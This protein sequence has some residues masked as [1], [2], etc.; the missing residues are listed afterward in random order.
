MNQTSKV[1]IHHHGGFYLVGG[2]R[3]SWWDDKRF[4][5]G[6]TIKKPPF[7]GCT[8]NLWG[9]EA[10]GHSSNYRD[11]ANLVVGCMDCGCCL[12]VV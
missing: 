11:L 6:G 5:H 4:V 3:P 1:I 2:S 8:W 10:L 9:E 7:D 12:E